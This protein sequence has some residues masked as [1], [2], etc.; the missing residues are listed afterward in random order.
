MKRY[1]Y[2]ALV[3]LLPD[4]DGAPPALPAATT[5]MVIKAEHR[6]THACKLF[7]SL[8]TI[9]DA[10]ARRRRVT[11]TFVVLGDDAGD[12]LATG[13]RFALWNGRELGLGV[14]TRRIF[15]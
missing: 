13:E 8:I 2:Q 5:R 12:Y 10:V 14:I 15:V 4:D 1:K 3:T 6:E 7:S 11:V 9:D